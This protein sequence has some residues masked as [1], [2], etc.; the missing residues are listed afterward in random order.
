MSR[1]KNSHASFW[2]IILII[3]GLLFLL[4]N[5]NYLDVGDVIGRYWPLILVI[6]GIR[7]LLNQRQR[8]EHPSGS[9]GDSASG[10][11]TEPM[12]SKNKN[13]YQSGHNHTQNSTFGDMRIRISGQEPVRDYYA[14][15]V[16]GDI[17]LDF[18]EARFEPPA[19]VRVSGVFGDV[20]VRVPQTVAVEAKV[21]FTAGSSRIFGEHQDGLVKTINYRSPDISPD[22][23]IVYLHISIIFGDVHVHY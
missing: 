18:S 2:G 4:Q 1:S 22:Q 21:N 7:M 5:M 23:Q 8:A 16:F 9:S 15:N 6:I 3:F 13:T 20:I 17:D 14:N 12:V 10:I 19:S 11:Q